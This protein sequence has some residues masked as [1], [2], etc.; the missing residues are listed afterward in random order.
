MSQHASPSW[1]KLC[2]SATAAGDS[3]DIDDAGIHRHGL[4]RDWFWIAPGLYRVSKLANSI[5]LGIPLGGC[6]PILAYRSHLIYKNEIQAE[7]ALSRIETQ[8]FS[9]EGC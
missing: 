2:G 9:G 1:H 6:H 7:N 8:T 4:L 5:L 3:D